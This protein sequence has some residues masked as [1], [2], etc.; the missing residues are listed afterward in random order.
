MGLNLMVDYFSLSLLGL[1][2]F[3]H[4]PN[5]RQVI[6]HN[7]IELINKLMLQVA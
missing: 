7:L 4:R 6:S 5:F 2:H 1:I 3:N